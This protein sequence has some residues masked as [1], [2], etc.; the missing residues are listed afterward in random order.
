MKTIKKPQHLYRH[1][2]IMWYRNVIQHSMPTSSTSMARDRERGEKSCRT[3][4]KTMLKPQHLYMCN[5]IE[6]YRIII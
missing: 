4:R 2:E 6:W 1:N 5:A 3:R